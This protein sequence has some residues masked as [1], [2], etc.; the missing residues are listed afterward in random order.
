MTTSISNNMVEVTMVG[1]LNDYGYA[2]KRNLF[3]IKN[4]TPDII[5]IA[6]PIIVEYLI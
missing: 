6:L 1:S 3:F 2:V 5:N 4:I